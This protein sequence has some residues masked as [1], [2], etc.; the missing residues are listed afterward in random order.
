MKITTHSIIV[1]KKDV[2]SCDLGDE[3]YTQPKN[4]NI[5]RIRPRRSTDLEPHP[6]TQTTKRN[7]R[8]TPK[9]IRHRKK[10]MPTRL[11]RI[12]KTTLRERTCKDKIKIEE[13]K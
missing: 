4:W 10:R 8:N 5:L 3:I 7:P 11:N 12:T 1:V 2:I 13:L 9:R 6:N